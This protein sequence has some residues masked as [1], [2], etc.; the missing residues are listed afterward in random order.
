MNKQA[1]LAC[2]ALIL[3][4]LNLYISSTNLSSN[5]QQQIHA[6]NLLLALS[7]F[8]VSAYHI[9]KTSTDGN[10]QNKVNSES[11]VIKGKTHFCTSSIMTQ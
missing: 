7:R 6:C 3:F 9:D 10:V 5:M 8:F 4:H 2:C 11:I 1:I